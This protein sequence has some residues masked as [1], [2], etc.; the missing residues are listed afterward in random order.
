MDSQKPL[1]I[2]HQGERTA[3]GQN[4]LEEHRGGAREEP[5]RGLSAMPRP[6]RAVGIHVQER[7]GGLLFGETGEFLF[8][9]RDPVPVYQPHAA[10]WHPQG[11]RVL[12]YRRQALVVQVAEHEAEGRD[13]NTRA[14]FLC[15]DA[16]A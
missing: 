4:A 6:Q 15:F 5:Q 2:F 16:T 1:G 10:L 8:Q 11:M 13:T 12:R 3:D 7:L 9:G 14:L